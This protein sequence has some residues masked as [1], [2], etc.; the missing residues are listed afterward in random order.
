LTNFAATSFRYLRHLLP[1]KEAGDGSD[2]STQPAWTS[3]QS[4]VLDGASAVALIESRLAESAALG[5]A[6]PASLAARA[7]NRHESIDQTNLFNHPISGLRS[8]DARGTLSAA[9]GLAMSGQRA[10]TFL[11][12]PDLATAHDLLHFA[13]GRHIPLVIHLANRA[14]SGHAQ[15]IGNGHEAYTNTANTGLIQLYAINAQEAADLSVIL[16]HTVERA[17]VPGL[18]AQDGEQTAASAQ[19]VRL[20]DDETLRTYLGSPADH[21]DVPTEAQRLLFGDTRRLVPRQYDLERPMMHAPLQDTESW[22]LGEAADRLYFLEPV[23][24]L[25]HASFRTFADQTGRRYDSIFTHNLENA[26]IV[27]VAQGSAVENAVALSRFLQAS[28]GPPVGVLGVR[29]FRPFPAEQ[30]AKALGNAATIAVLENTKTQP[31]TDLPLLR[32]IRAALRHDQKTVSVRYGRGGL[33]LHMADLAAL[34]DQFNQSGDLR[35]SYDLGFNYVLQDDPRP[36]RQALMDRLQRVHSDLDSLS[37]HTDISPPDVRP[38]GSTTIAVHRTAG[39]HEQLFHNQWHRFSTCASDAKRSDFG[40]SVQGDETVSEQS[41]AGDIAVLIH[42]L[43]GGHLRT[44]PALTRQRTDEPCTDTITHIP[45]AGENV[46]PMFDPGDDVSVDIAVIASSRIHENM[47][48]TA[49]L[50]DGGIVLLA[51]DQPDDATIAKI[52]PAK[53]KQAIESKHAKLYIVPIDSDGPTSDCLVHEQLLGGLV[54]LFME[55]TSQPIDTSDD[56]KIQ[57]IRN[58][59][60]SDESNHEQTFN[61]FVA[62]FKSVHQL[63]APLSTQPDTASSD[64]RVPLAVRHLSRSDTTL[65]NLPRFWDQVGILYKTSET[66]RLTADPYMACGSIPPLSSTFRDVSGS[67]QTLPKFDPTTCDGNGRLWTTCPDGSIAP[68]VISARALL[69]TGIDLAGAAG[70]SADALRRIASK[71]AG[72]VNRVVKQSEEPPTTAA[73][74]LNAAFDSLMEKSDESDDNKA[75]LK[76]A[77]QSVIMEIGDLPLSRTELFFDEPERQSKGSGELFSLAINPDACKCPELILAVNEN[78]GLTAVEQTPQ[79]LTEARRLW[80]LWQKLPDTSGET[81]QR[82]R[83][84]DRVGSLAAIMLSR[85]CQFAMAGGDGAEPASG[86]KLALRNVLALAEYH[87]QPRL[88]EHLTTIEKWRSELSDQIRQ[89]L[90]SALPVDDLDAL[91]KGL[92]ALGQDEIDLSSLTER[93]DS[94]VSSSTVDGARLSRLVEVS[95]GLADLRWRL[96]TGIDGLGRARIGLVLAPGN[97]INWAGV[98]PHNPFQSPVVLDPCGE[99][100]QLALGLLEGQMRQSVAFVRLLRWAQL[101]VQQ[102]GRAAH[103]AKQLTALRYDELTGEERTLCP[104]ILLIVDARS[105]GGRNLSEIVNLLRSNR[106]VKILILNDLSGIAD[107]DQLNVDAFG[108]YPGSSG[109]P[110]DTAFLALLSRSAYITQ[111]SIANPDHLTQSVLTA[112][113]TD[114]PALIHIHAPSPERHGFPTHR[115]HEQARLAVQSRAYPLFTFDPS[116]EGIFGSHLDLSGN[117]NPDSPLAATDDAEPITP[118]DWAFTEARFADHFTLLTPDDPSPVPVADYLQKTKAEQHGSTPYITKPHPTTNE[119]VKYRISE[120][121]INDVEAR[122]NLWRTLQELAGVVTPFTEKVQVQ[123]EEKLATIHEQ[124]LVELKKT[125]DQDLAQQ[126]A[127]FESEAVQRI[128]ARLMALASAGHNGTDSGG[129]NETS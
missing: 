53:F 9:I 43:A 20:I 22:A 56:E 37:I 35:S 101:E 114:G 40:K 71:L 106:P 41:P 95:R 19:D 121:L 76:E 84:D 11:S 112:L 127:G 123:V 16:R 124:E 99:T 122:L 64:E 72:R 107:T 51:V 28:G 39:T 126:K 102:P 42:T 104:P 7:W 63:S 78:H 115:L 17:L 31:D 89:L 58:A 82:V 128:T 97:M 103:D 119:P 21:I 46:E 4:V 65:D 48:P 5:A 116:T 67:R 60:P 10:V 62:G 80:D 44:R 38:T 92:E 29:C 109:Q 105:V 113:S 27:L 86:A 57:A 88:R 85:H 45:D 47:N 24:T 33:P 129:E 74:L 108:R 8:D 87:L 90:S 93:I 98:F 77:L 73:G 25:L 91:S 15:P 26:Q 61:A 52:L 120:T 6:H 96:E 83:D 18:L 2:A 118:L 75:A 49:W 79:N 81:I 100:G 66:D 3:G 69:D 54:R 117:P 68:L 12:G 94:A 55:R 14:L 59:L 32:E 23:A 34:I 111:T 110:F 30:I 13:A 70:R 125:C 1:F 36:K 50:V